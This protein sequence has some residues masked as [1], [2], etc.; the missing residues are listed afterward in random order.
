MTSL[1]D[2]SLLFPPLVL[3]GAAPAA[4]LQLLLPYHC[5]FVLQYLYK[6]KQIILFVADISTPI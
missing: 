5:K 3:A 1:P 4:V 6:W 2:V